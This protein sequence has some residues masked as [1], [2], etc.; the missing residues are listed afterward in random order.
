MLAP[1]P[2]RQ[3]HGTLSILYNRCYP[4][5]SGAGPL[6]EKEGID[7]GIV[8][9]I[10]A[11]SLLTID[12]SGNGGHGGGMPMSHRYACCLSSACLAWLLVC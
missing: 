1:A 11:P 7:I 5:L 6:L 9:A 3:V 2:Q 4:K 12:F 10:L 8:E